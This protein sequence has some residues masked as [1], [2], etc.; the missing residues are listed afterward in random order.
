MTNIAGLAGAFGT[1][2]ISMAI[3]A[4]PDIILG[5]M[6]IRNGIKNKD[7]RAI[8]FGKALMNIASAIPIAGPTIKAIKFLFQAINAKPIIGKII[9]NIIGYITKYIPKPYGEKVYN[10]FKEKIEKQYGV[11]DESEV[12]NESKIKPKPLLTETQ[13]KRWQTLANI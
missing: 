1:A 7:K 6:N 8:Y 9:I 3:G 4:L 5:I 12:Q 11:K 10:F 13:I 2:G